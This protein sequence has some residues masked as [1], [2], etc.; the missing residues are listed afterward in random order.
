MD[1]I[2][3]LQ[4]CGA[5][6]YALFLCLMGGSGF[7]FFFFFVKLAV[8]NAAKFVFLWKCVPSCLPINYFA[9]K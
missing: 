4:H 6:Y 2:A 7:F 8:V 5:C 1:D 3:K 9:S